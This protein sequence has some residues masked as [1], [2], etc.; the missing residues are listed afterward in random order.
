LYPSPH[1]TDLLSS[2][3]FDTEY[4]SSTWDP[5][6]QTHTL[7]LRP[8]KSTGDPSRTFTHTTDILISANGPLS[9]PLIPKIPGL[10]KFQGIAFHNLHWRR[11]TTQNNDNVDFQT[12]RIAVI[13]NGSSAIQLIPG[14]ASTPGVELTQYIR[15]GGYYFP[16]NNTPIP[17]HKQFLYRYLPFAR[18]LHRYGLFAAHNDRWKTR[19]DGDADGHDETEKVLLDYLRRTAPEEYLEALMPRYRESLVVAGFGLAL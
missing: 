17:V 10:D 2:F 9:T 3:I 13:G 1:N 5:T 8:T 19:N 7:T 16:K 18:Y 4:V 11:V 14:L 15:S 6:S 12:K